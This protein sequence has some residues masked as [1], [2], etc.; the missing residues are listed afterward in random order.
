MTY[1]VFVPIKLPTVPIKKAYAYSET[2]AVLQSFNR[3][4]AYLHYRGQ[5]Y[6][7]KRGE[8]YQF[9]IEHMEGR[10]KLVV[11]TERA[12]GTRGIDL[13]NILPRE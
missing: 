2:L 3:H 4:F 8:T 12:D 11:V 6:R 13:P 5:Y 10:G 9:A 1:T 7:G